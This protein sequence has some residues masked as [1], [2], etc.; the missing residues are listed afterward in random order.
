MPERLGDEVVA[1]VERKMGGGISRHCNESRSRSLLT[2]RPTVQ[3]SWF[4]ELPIV[5][6]NGGFDII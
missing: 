5:N 6:R 3:L 2:G 1:E 4:S